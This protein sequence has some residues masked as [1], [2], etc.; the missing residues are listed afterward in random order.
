MVLTTWAGTVPQWALLE[1]RV[2]LGNVS[3]VLEKDS[4]VLIRT[5]DVV[6]RPVYYRCREYNITVSQRN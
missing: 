1:R 5:E 6:T 4:S 3:F 2:L